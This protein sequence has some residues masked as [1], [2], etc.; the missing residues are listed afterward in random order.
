MQQDFC[1][2]RRLAM[3]DSAEVNEINAGTLQADPRKRAIKRICFITGIAFIVAF[4]L[5]ITSSIRGL[6]VI[7]SLN[8]DLT[9][10]LWYLL[11]FVSLAFLTKTFTIPLTSRRENSIT[12][13]LGQWTREPLQKTITFWSVPWS[14]LLAGSISAGIGVLNILIFGLGT[15][16]SAKLGQI[17]FLGGP[18]VAYLTGLYPALFGF[19]LLGYCIF[20]VNRLSFGESEHW[21]VLL[22]QKLP[23]FHFTEILKSEVAGISIRNT[24]FGGKFG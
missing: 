14:R 4:A 1:P 6:V 11:F 7:R 3:G 2:G 13:R 8:L 18:S 15:A 23:T 19:M 12:L 20:S 24:K 21:F 17:L 22:E 9:F 5:L 10:V 16:D